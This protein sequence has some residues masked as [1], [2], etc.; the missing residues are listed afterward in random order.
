MILQSSC[1]FY[2][3]LIIALFL[4]VISIFYQN[5]FLTKIEYI[6]Y[7]KEAHRP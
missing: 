2:V 1:F 4:Y 5:Y 7:K 6:S 3:T